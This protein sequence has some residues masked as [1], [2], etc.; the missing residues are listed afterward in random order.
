[1]FNHGP[2]QAARLAFGL[3][4]LGRMADVVG[5]LW[6][7]DPLHGTMDARFAGMWGVALVV[8]VIVYGVLSAVRWSPRDPERMLRT[9]W[10]VLATGV[11]LA[12]PLS[13]HLIWMAAHRGTA[14]FDSWARLSLYVTGPAHVVFAILAASRARRLA[15]GEQAVSVPVI[16]MAVVGASMVPLPGFAIPIILMTAPPLVALLYAMAPLIRGERQRCLLPRAE[17]LAPDAA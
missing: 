6:S 1:M 9:S 5:A 3:V 17:A 15:L 12:L 11:A 14:S 7:E 4:L 16:V 2:G 8:A 10:T 13:L